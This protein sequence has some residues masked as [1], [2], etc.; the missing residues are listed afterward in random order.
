CTD[1]TWPIAIPGGYSESSPLETVPEVTTYSPATAGV[2]TGR[3]WSSRAFGSP[4]FG[5]TIPVA[6]LVPILAET[7]IVL[8]V[9]RSTCAPSEATW[10]TLPTKPSPLTTGSLTRTP[11]AAPLSIVTVAY[12]M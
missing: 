5:C 9:M 1:V 2:L 7:P 10:A 12:Q 4:T 8:S 3:Y 11:A 6:L